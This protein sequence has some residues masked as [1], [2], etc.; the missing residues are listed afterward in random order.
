MWVGV[1][2]LPDRYCGEFKARVIKIKQGV[3]VS[4]NPPLSVCDCGSEPRTIK[5]REWGFLHPLDGSDT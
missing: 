2:Q 4:D 1:V 3:R 5:S